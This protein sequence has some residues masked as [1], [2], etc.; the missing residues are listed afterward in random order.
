V[1][2]SGGLL[3][4]VNWAI[5]GPRFCFGVVGICR[6]SKMLCCWTWTV[7][8]SVEVVMMDDGSADEAATKL[9]L[10]RLQ[11]RARATRLSWELC[12]IM[13]GL[14]NTEGPTGRCGGHQGQKLG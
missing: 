9:Q 6:V 2:R 12:P 3:D 7:N 5:L 11:G 4:E 13:H 1:S 10:A 8:S 14:G